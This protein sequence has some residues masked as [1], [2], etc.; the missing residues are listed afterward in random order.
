MKIGWTLVFAGLIM[1]GVSPF[2]SIVLLF[3]ATV[4]CLLGGRLI[5]LEY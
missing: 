1:F 4:S 3:P 2:T 5:K